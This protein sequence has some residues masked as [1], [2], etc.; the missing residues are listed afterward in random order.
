MHRNHFMEDV[1]DSGTS[2]S[3]SSTTTVENGDYKRHPDWV[4]KTNVIH[5][6]REASR[7]QNYNDSRVENSKLAHACEFGMQRM[8]FGCDRG[9]DNFRDEKCLLCQSVGRTCSGEMKR[10]Q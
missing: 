5:S 8:E 7:N 1:W 3:L 2:Q 9:F 10:I 4:E 6:L